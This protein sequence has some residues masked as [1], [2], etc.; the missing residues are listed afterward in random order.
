MNRIERMFLSLIIRNSIALLLFLL[1]GLLGNYCAGKLILSGRNM[2]G[3][4]LPMLAAFSLIA[5]LFSVW[6]NWHS[7]ISVQSRAAR[8]ALRTTL[9]IIMVLFML[10]V[11]FLT[12]AHI[13]WV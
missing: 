3:A 12:T 11:D 9:I 2:P 5:T 4:G 7:F 13:E 6:A 8:L 1:I 10:L